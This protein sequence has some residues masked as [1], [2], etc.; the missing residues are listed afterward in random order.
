[1]DNYISSRSN[2]LVVLAA[3]LKQKKYREEHGLYICEGRKLCAEA[4]G[5]TVVKYSLLCESK[6]SEDNKRIAELS[7]AP[8]YV[9]SESAFSKVSDDVSSD[10]ILFINEISSDTAIVS[11]D[12]KVIFLDSVRDPG[13]LGTIIRSSVAFGFDKVIAYDCA[14]VYNPKVVR[15]SMGALFNVGVIKSD[16]AE[17]SI[18]ELKEQGRKIYSATLHEE[19]VSLTEIVK[20]PSDVFVIGNEGHGISDSVIAL[21]DKCVI[22]PISELSESLNAS[23]AASVIMWEYSILDYGR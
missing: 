2:P 18:A 4:V 22:I 10:G 7:R 3:S 19:A 14:D 23:I 12:D 5:K 1:M 9:L 16:N 11:A 6:L 13:N 17:V 20:K 15:A 8:I 21:S